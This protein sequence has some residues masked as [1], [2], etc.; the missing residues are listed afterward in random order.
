MLPFPLS[1]TT[2]N[3]SDLDDEK[4]LSDVPEN[5]SDGSSSQ[6]FSSQAHKQIFEIELESSRGTFLYVFW[7]SFCVGRNPNRILYLT[8][9]CK[10][11]TRESCQVLHAIHYDAQHN[12]YY[13]RPTREA[14]HSHD[15]GT[16]MERVHSLGYGLSDQEFS[17]RRVNSQIGKLMFIS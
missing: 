15:F 7:N 3:Q 16:T 2:S 17:V 9:A 8:C 6:Q 1:E 10:L 4:L 5:V 12:V 14:S 11:N 13:L